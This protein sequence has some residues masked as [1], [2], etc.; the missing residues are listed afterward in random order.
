MHERV[1]DGGLLFGRRLRGGGVEVFRGALEER[2]G[3][4][5]RRELEVRRW[6]LRFR[7]DERLGGIGGDLHRVVAEL[8]VLLLD[9]GALRVGELHHLVRIRCNRARERRHLEREDVR[10]GEAQHEA[11]GRLRLR[12]AV[13]ER[14]IAEADVVVERVVHRVI[15]AAARLPAVADVHR[16]DAD[17]L[18][19]RRVVGA[20]AQ[21]IEAEQLAVADLLHPLRQRR[22][23]EGTGALALQHR[24]LLFRIGDVA[25]HLRHQL[26]EGV[27]AAGIEKAAA[28]G[29]GVDVDRDVVAHVIRVRLDPF[30]RPEE[31]WLLAV[32]CGVDERAA[33]TPAALRQLG[34]R[35]RL[36]EHCHLAADRVRRAVDPRVV[37]VAA[38]DP[39]IG[40]VGACHL[41]DDVVDRLHV[42]VERDLEVHLRVAGEVIRDRERAAPVGRRDRA[43]HRAQQRQR[44]AVRDREHRDLRQRRGVLHREALRVFRGA[45]AGRERIA[46]VR[47]HVGD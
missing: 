40:A 35:A 17:V 36:F 7:R 4:L 34:D 30:G 20:G 24:H 18:E 2:H 14:R 42:P 37:M 10:I 44:V 33:R 11:A 28:V 27:R 6:I 39:L 15:R 46:G 43:R 16:G 47:R 13:V 26:L 19:E 29:V 41:R 25:R 3:V 45:D 22:G 12:D 31:A 5:E 21:G 23:G 1:V 9:L 8:A 32:P 38:H